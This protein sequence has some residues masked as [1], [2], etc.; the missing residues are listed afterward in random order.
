MHVD[1]NEN[2]IEAFVAGEF[3]QEFETYEDSKIIADCMWI[4]EKF[5]GK[6]V[7]QPINMARTRWLTNNDFLG[8]YAYPMTQGGSNISK[9]LGESILDDTGKPSLLFA[10]EATSEKYQGY[11]HGAI[12]TGWK[13]ANELTDFYK[14]K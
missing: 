9:A 2:V 14:T 13:V 1:D 12:Q 3:L 7:K 6:S 4:I 10:G 5:L 11:V 8:S